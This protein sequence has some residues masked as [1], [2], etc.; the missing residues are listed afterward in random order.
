VEYHARDNAEPSLDDVIQA[1]LK[2]TGKLADAEG[3]AVEVKRAVDSRILEALLALA[4][5]PG[6]SAEARGTVRLT[7][8]SLRDDY[9]RGS[10]NK[11]DQAFRADEV[12][13]I[14][15]FFRDPAKFVP[16]KPIPSPP[17]MPIGEEE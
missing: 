3:L 1:T 6:A 12:A 4:A 8:Q 13:R 2:A 7:L 11:E 10:E 5:N 14:D 9:A 16:A 15:E 17:G